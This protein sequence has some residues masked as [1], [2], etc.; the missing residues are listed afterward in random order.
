M[1]VHRRFEISRRPHQFD[2][3]CTVALHMGEDTGGS[4]ALNLDLVGPI[5]ILG[6]QE[7][8]LQRLQFG[9]FRLGACGIAGSRL[10]EGPAERDHR[11][12]PRE[13]L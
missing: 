10:A 11:L 5:G 6:C 1:L 12:S 9:D 7:L 13:A 3:L 4:Q 8:V 2:R